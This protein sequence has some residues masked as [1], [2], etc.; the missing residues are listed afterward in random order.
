MG[1]VQ[2]AGGNGRF[3]GRGGSG[4]AKPSSFG[5][6]APPLPWWLNC[7][8]SSAIYMMMIDGPSVGSRFHY[9]SHAYAL[10]LWAPRCGLQPILVLAAPR[11]RGS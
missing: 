4:R 3:G 11:G 10:T 2:S 8:V 6:S 5:R 7:L 1:S 9:L